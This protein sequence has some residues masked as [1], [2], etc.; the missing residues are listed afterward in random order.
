VKRLLDI[1]CGRGGWSKPFLDR[2]WHCT[3]VD[4]KDLQYCGQQFWQRDALTLELDELNKFNLIVCSPPC[5]EFARAW[6][7]WLCFDKKADETLLRWAVGLVGKV[8]CPV[9]VECSKFAARHV[10]GAILIGSWAFWGDTP[11]I[12]PV[13]GGGKQRMSGMRPDL[14]AMVP[15]EFGAWLAQVYGGSHV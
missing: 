10:P 11:A 8:R 2:E 7:P 3:G 6:L 12:M 15:Y 13:I 9:V 14:R 4:L 5:E 1:F